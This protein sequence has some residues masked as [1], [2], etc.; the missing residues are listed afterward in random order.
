[1][2][3]GPHGTKARH[4]AV[5]QNLMRGDTGKQAM[6]NAGYSSTY[7]HSNSRRVV[8][9]EA[10]R[11]ALLEIKRNIRPGELGDL[12]EAALQ[13]ELLNLP[14]GAKNL[15]A[16]V[17]VIRTGLE[18]DARIGGPAELHLHN[19]NQLPKVVEEMLLAKMEE[20]QRMKE[21]AVDG[22]LVSE[23]PASESENQENHDG[24]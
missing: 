15:K 1:M 3:R 7:A 20:L 17:S 22:E 13:Q 16:R 10:V 12:S 8:K 5:A 21:E 24:V 19:H 4:Y 2:G 11:Q 9:S 18:V 14:K 6:V 23:R